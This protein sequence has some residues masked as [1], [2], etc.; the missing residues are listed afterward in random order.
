MR[1]LYGALMVGSM[2]LV[3]GCGQQP[4][5]QLIVVVDTD[6]AIPTEVDEIVVDV[7]GPDG[8][9]HETRT[10]MARA[11]ELPYTLTVVPAHGALG[12]ITITARGDHDGANVVTRVARVTLVA[13]ET[14]MVRLYLLHRCGDVPPACSATSTCGDAGVCVSIDVLGEPWTGHPPR[15]GEDAAVPRIDA[16][17]PHDAG[18]R[19][20]GGDG[21]P[22]PDCHATGCDDGEACTDD[23]CG[24]D[25]LCTHV[26]NAIGCDDGIFCNGNDSCG[27]GACTVHAGPPCG[28]GQCD[29]ASRACGVCDTDDMCPMP[30]RGTFGACMVAGD[31]CATD[32]TQ[33]RP[34]Q[35]FHCVSRACV[36]TDSTESQA[37]TRTTDGNGCGMT[38]CGAYGV[39]NGAPGDAC[40]TSGTQSRT[41][42]D[43]VCS[44]G[45]CVGVDRAESAGCTRAT[46]GISCMTTTCTDWGTCGG[47]ADTC[48]T[49]GTQTRTC[50]DYACGGGS[51]Q[52]SVRTETQGCPRSTDGTSCG[53]TS[54]GSFGACGG[55][56]DV[57][58]T[59]G[60]YSRTC[61]DLVCSGGTCTTQP[62]TDTQPCTGPDTTGIQ[63]D[64]DPG[65]CRNL[66]C[67]NGTCSR[68]VGT[69]SGSRRCC[70]GVCLNI[71]P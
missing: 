27:G 53:A 41:C 62:R 59:A 60:T 37:C 3:A 52:G 64:S 30:I 31:A 13:S 9:H 7:V 16:A 50:T 1:C 26:A 36:P 23:T 15:I 48:A 2:A 55:F 6:Y 70:D 56:A 65:L 45:S 63:C 46:D 58:A 54:C 14:R 5:T 68:S 57:C 66:F 67:A 24:S 21:G 43:R 11:S 19:P 32:G 4:P 38:S 20:D 35:T 10:S 18:A 51:C 71:C 61:N 22:P 29:E 40:G 39:C 69:C 42:T 8:Q 34:V 25:G 17:V 12:P 49:S 44:G 47:F 28:A 33:S